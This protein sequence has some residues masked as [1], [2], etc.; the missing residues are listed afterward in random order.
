MTASTPLLDLLR[1][2]A[3]RLTSH[4][5]DA[6][7]AG[8]ALLVI[9]GV[10][11]SAT[12]PLQGDVYASPALVVL[13]VVMF[14]V[15]P[16][17]LVL[18]WRSWHPMAPLAMPIV[19]ILGLTGLSVLGGE[20]GPLGFAY[21]GMYFMA[22][23][24]TG[25]WLPARASWWLL[26]PAAASYPLLV[27]AWDR[28]VALRMAVV[29]VVW[30]MAGELVAHL[31]ARQR[32]TEQAL[33]TATRRDALTRLDNRRGLAAQLEDLV[34]GEVVVMLDLDHFK[35]VNDTRGHAGGDAV[36]ADF[37]EVLTGQL[38]VGDC[39]ARYGGEEFVLVLAD[40]DLDGAVGVL[41]RL[42]AAW[43]VVQPG[44]TFSS[45]YVRHE[46]GTAPALSLGSADAA[47]YAAKTAGRNCDVLAEGAVHQRA[48]RYHPVLVPH[49]S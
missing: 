45:G 46:P 28:H 22:F 30:V 19:M 1:R 17:V 24:H 47:L 11:T 15:K 29:V 32:A 27:G 25:V 23:V 33:R 48:D 36:L 37:A 5:T 18:P 9:T 34:G 35:A 10:I 42:R 20:L 26:L 12:L 2:A 44:V 49:S 31:Q 41:A 13:G 21:V 39:A 16:L 3:P 6:A 14:V 7:L 4:C 8:F 38:R 40:A 43:A